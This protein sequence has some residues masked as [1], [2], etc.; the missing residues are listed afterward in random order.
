MVG[1]PLRFVVIEVMAAA[2]AVMSTQSQLSVFTVGV[3]LEA[4]EVTRLVTRLLV[5]V[6]VPASVASVPVVGR[7]TFV[8]P[9]LVS[10]MELAPEV[11]RDDPSAMVSVEDVAGA[12]IVTLLMEVAVATPRT[13]VTKVGEVLNTRTPDPVSFDTAVISWA[14]VALKVLLVRLI[15]LLVRV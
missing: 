12:V 15:T 13:G 11:I 6:S 1:V 4:I 3:A 10:V 9:V 7:V 5:S 8:A 14:E 2:R